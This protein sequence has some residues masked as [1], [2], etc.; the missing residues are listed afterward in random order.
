MSFQ[1][2]KLT[3]EGME[4]AQ[5]LNLPLEYAANITRTV[6]STARQIVRDTPLVRGLKE[7]YK[8][9]CQVCGRV[10]KIGKIQFYAEAHHMKPLGAP[11]HGPDVSDNLIIL[12]AQHHVEFDYQIMALKIQLRCSL[13]IM[14]CTIHYW[15]NDWFTHSIK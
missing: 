3:K 4:V 14:T 15:A 12:C 10:T 6:E 13:N 11:H 5:W 7:K 8:F 9:Q 2:W 1:K